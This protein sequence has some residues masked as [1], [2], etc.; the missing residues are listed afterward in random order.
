MITLLILAGSGLAIL[1]LIGLNAWLGGWT[2][3]RIDSL[4]AALERFR[5]DYLDIAPAGSVLSSDGKAVLIADANSAST[6]MVIAQGDI[7]V[8][9][10][11]APED[12]AEAR[13]DGAS[14]MIRFRDFTFPSTRI[15]LA[16]D[17]EAARWAARLQ[18]AH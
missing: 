17:A 8:S 9:R 13:P 7:L 1:A 11:V 5:R 14:L 15:E 18:G 2:P 12:V 6:G 16:D 3:S 10:L 4:D